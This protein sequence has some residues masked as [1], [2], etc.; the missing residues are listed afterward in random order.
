MNFALFAHASASP[1]LLPLQNLFRFLCPPSFAPLPSDLPASPERRG[2]HSPAFLRPAA[3]RFELGKHPAAHPV[4][5]NKPGLQQSASA[6]ATTAKPACR[7]R[8]PAL[9]VVRMFES[10]QS[11]KTVGRM[12]ISGRMADVCAELDRLVGREQ[13]SR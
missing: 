5:T 9:R 8:M 13:C 4:E 12:V 7:Q 3:I 10:G 2:T 11:P 1:T 6:V